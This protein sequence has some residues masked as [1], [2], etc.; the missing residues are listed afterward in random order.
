MKY[1]NGFLPEKVG[2]IVIFTVSVKSSTRLVFRNASFNR[3]KPITRD[4][5]VCLTASRTLTGFTLNRTL[6]DPA[7][8]AG[9]VIFPPDGIATTESRVIYADDLLHKHRRALE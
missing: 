5:P 2:M 9:S 7:V 4:D 8:S 1:C 6:K 3:S